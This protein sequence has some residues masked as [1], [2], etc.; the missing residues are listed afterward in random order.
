MLECR[1][2]AGP[3]RQERRHRPQEVRLGAEPLQGRRRAAGGRDAAAGSHR[4]VPAGPALAARGAVRR[5]DPP[6]APSSRPGAARRTRPSVRLPDPGGTHGLS[7]PYPCPDH[8]GGPGGGGRV[9]SLRRPRS[10]G[11]PLSERPHL[12]L[13]CFLGYSASHAKLSRC[14][15]VSEKRGVSQRRGT[16]AGCGLSA[17]LGILG[18]ESPRLPLLPIL[19][20]SFS[21]L[22]PG[23]LSAVTSGV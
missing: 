7:P 12:R 8:A 18:G 9:T 16:Q 6:V 13:C 17:F 14:Q 22:F 11:D 21:P 20:L 23:G 1:G 19:S 10:G 15:S 3:A 5:R 2:G 4:A